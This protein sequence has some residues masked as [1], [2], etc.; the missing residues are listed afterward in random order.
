MGKITEEMILKEVLP[1]QVLKGKDFK[2]YGVIAESEL[3]E[4]I[5][6]NEEQSARTN[7]FDEKVSIGASCCLSGPDL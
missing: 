6:S 2:D 4:R 5:I 3:K 7:L 1:D